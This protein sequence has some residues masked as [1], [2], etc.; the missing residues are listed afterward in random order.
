MLYCH[1]S[2]VF[3]YRRK[4]LKQHNDM[5]KPQT[6]TWYFPVVHDLAF[7]RFQTPIRVSVAILTVACK[8]GTGKKGTGKKGTGKKGTRKKWHRKKWHKVHDRKKR[9]LLIF[10]IVYFTDSKNA[11]KWPPKNQKVALEPEGL[12]PLMEAPTQSLPP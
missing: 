9:H 7:K 2:V 3:N 12:H 6:M 11:E 8:K 1:S 4:D 10:Q 5:L